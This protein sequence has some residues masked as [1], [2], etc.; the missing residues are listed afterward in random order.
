MLK[1]HVKS[2]KFCIKAGVS[3]RILFFFFAVAELHKAVSKIQVLAMS[4]LLKITHSI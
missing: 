2:Y 4:Y 1:L 3:M